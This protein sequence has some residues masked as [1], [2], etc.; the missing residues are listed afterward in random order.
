MGEPLLP[1]VAA[2]LEFED[3]T[4]ETGDHAEK[5]NCALVDLG[6]HQ[7]FG[8]VGAGEGGHEVPHQVH[9]LNGDELALL[10]DLVESL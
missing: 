4:G 6:A 1:E 5:A 10:V 2:L 3:D 8:H 9:K 7:D